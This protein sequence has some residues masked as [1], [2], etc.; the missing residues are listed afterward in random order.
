[1]KL[2]D[3]RFYTYVSQP[4]V[5]NVTNLDIMPKHVHHTT[6]NLKARVLF[7]PKM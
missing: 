6:Q 3:K 2:C 4:N 5:K 1:M 7:D